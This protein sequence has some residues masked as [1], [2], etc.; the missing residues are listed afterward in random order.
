MSAWHYVEEG[1]AKG[2]LTEADLK[3]RLAAGRLP[4]STLVWRE[5]MA[6]WQEA[7]TIRELTAAGSAS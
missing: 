7:G 3:E 2:P 5:G 4:G 6:N 1:A